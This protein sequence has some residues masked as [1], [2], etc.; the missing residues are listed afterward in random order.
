[1]RWTVDSSI[2]SVNSGTCLC[3][4]IQSARLQLFIISVSFVPQVTETLVITNLVFY[5]KASP[6]YVNTVAEAEAFKLSLD[7]EQWDFRH[8]LGF[9]TSP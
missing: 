9:H 1:M 6:K 7:A 3:Q 8:C 2:V 5:K 4:V